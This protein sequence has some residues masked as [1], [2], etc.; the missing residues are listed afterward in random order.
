MLNAAIAVLLAWNIAGAEVTADEP[1]QPVVDKGHGPVVKSAKRLKR[2]STKIKP[3]SMEAGDEEGT[4][5]RSD[6]NPLKELKPSS[7]WKTRKPSLRTA[8]RGPQPTK[9]KP[10]ADKGSQVPED[11][12]PQDKRKQAA[13]PVESAPGKLP[14]GVESTAIESSDEDAASDDPFGE[15]LED[16][17][18]EWEEDEWRDETDADELDDF[19]QDSS[20][21]DSDEE[22]E[23]EEEME[24]EEESETG[25][26]EDV[27]S[28]E[29]AESDEPATADESTE[30]PSTSLP[31]KTEPRTEPSADE[32]SKRST[33]NPST[34][35]PSNDKPSGGTTKPEISKR[36]KPTTGLPN[37]ARQPRTGPQS[38]QHSALPPLDSQ[39]ILRRDRL[40]KA[41]ATY[42]Q[43][44]VNARDNT[45]W[46]TFHWVIAYNVYAEILANGPWGNR[47]N[48]VGWLCF[49][50]P[51]KG[52]YLLTLDQGRIKAQY[53]VGL[54][55]HEGQFLAILAQSRVMID[56]PLR[57]G[58]RNFTVSDLVR[59]EM[60]G[61]QSGTELTFK[62]IAL[63]HYLELDSQWKN[64]AGETWDIPRLIR[65]EIAKPIQGAA[66]G[67]TH[68]LM[69]LSYAVRMRKLRGEPIDGEYRRAE[70]YVRDYQKYAFSLQNADGSFSTNWLA[71]REAKTDVERRLQT[72][73]HILEWLIFSLPDAELKNPRIVQCVD[74]L[75]NI[76]LQEPNREWKIGPLGH[77]LRAL[78]LYDRRVYE[79]YDR[80]AQDLANEHDD[81][82]ADE[83]E[84]VEMD[85]VPAVTKKR[86][87]EDKS[88]IRTAAKPGPA[89]A[90]PTAELSPEKR[91][92]VSSP[93]ADD[94]DD[95]AEED[96]AE[97][98]E[99]SGE[100]PSDEDTTGEDD[101]ANLPEDLAD[102]D[103]EHVDLADDEDEVA[104]EPSSDDDQSKE[105][106]IDKKVETAEKPG[107]LRETPTSDTETDRNAPVRRAPRP[108][109]KP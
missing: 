101:Q 15:P 41:L 92:Q 88:S 52:Q 66:C 103:D 84:L 81:E 23:S 60:L 58:N 68:R 99:P 10:A 55:G 94:T 45:P 76:L 69:G 5:A 48:A 95:S 91:S 93:K 98:D 51:C 36:D 90:V 7:E 6:Q 65:E 2:R 80:P 43:R 16:D 77:G 50:R 47:T 96:A 78:T 53:G 27:I 100:T 26:D 102:E 75:T 70:A 19:D 63:S 11:E 14:E 35:K 31:P 49:N 46:E 13:T 29:D 21:D 57:V 8:N 37:K 22:I 108:L 24:S 30:Q 72:T 104:D 40:R 44:P 18:D 59:S 67:G 106:K 82:Q 4:P 79:A 25:D 62:L 17:V 56:Y 107:P 9:A 83:A 64:S 28:D 73:G 87:I 97:F 85:A 86:P 89:N 54:Q 3:A 61:C 12:R 105:T 20:I 34:D 42:Y 32:P 71:G 38:P 39:S 1:P 33:S 74:F 109:R